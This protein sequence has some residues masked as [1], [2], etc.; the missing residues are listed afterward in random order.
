MVDEVR[1]VTWEAPE[2]HHNEKSG[3]WY[4]AL[5]II[6]LAGAGASVVFGNTLFALVILLGAS[7]ILIFS[8]RKPSMLEFAVTVRGIRVGNELYPYS[9]LESFFLDEDEPMGP[10]LIV[11]SNHLFMPLIIMPIPEEYIDDIDDILSTRLKEEHLEEPLSH[12][13]LESLGF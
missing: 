6:A 13:L 2:H 5:G 4:W 12:K 10:Q 8:H 1:A 7:T 11:K 9:T 3:D